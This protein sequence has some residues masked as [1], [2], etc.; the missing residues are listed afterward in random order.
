MTIGFLLLQWRCFGFGG[1]RGMLSDSSGKSLDSA[2]SIE[3]PDPPILDSEGGGVPMD[4]VCLHGT[5]DSNGDSR[6][7]T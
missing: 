1:G 3:L 5:G 6:S 2:G 4:L 7:Y